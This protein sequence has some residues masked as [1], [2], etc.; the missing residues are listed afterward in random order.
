MSENQS[1]RAGGSFALA[2]GAWQAGTTNTQ[3]SNAAIVPFVV[4]G[5]QGSRSVTAAGY[6]WAITN[7]GGVQRHVG[8]T[9]RLYGLLLDAAGAVSM[10]QGAPVRTADLAAGSAALQ[11]PPVPPDR[12]MAGMVRV[13]LTA[14]LDFSPGFDPLT[15]AGNRT[16]TFFNTMAAPSEPLRS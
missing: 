8:G 9:T 5:R 6:P 16:V 12:A 4:N 1:A 14:G 2:S 7:P 3:P 11:A 15:T 10:S 13:S